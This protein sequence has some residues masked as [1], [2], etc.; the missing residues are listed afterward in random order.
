MVTFNQMLEQCNR[1][2]VPMEDPNPFLVFTGEG[3]DK[4]VAFH[5]IG[6]RLTIEQIVDIQLAEDQIFILGL[7]PL[8]DEKDIHI[9]KYEDFKN[10]TIFKE[11]Y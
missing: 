1:N 5:R 6:G 9:L 4:V 7:N 2:C 11:D 3:L 8:E 10:I